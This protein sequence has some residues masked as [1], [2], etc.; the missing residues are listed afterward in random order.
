M[1]NLQRLIHRAIIA[2]FCTANAS[3]D[4]LGMGLA[5]GFLPVNCPQK[6]GGFC[7]NRWRSRHMPTRV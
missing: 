6:G 7:Q 4:I 2:S 5:T 1:P 3:G